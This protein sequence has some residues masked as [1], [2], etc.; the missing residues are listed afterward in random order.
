MKSSP[1]DEHIYVNRK[2]Y[3]FMNFQ[4]VCDANLK[5][6]KVGKVAWEY[7][8][9]FDLVQF[10]IETNVCERH[11]F[12]GTV[13]RRQWLTITSMADDTCSQPNLTGEQKI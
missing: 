3:H 7:P 1:T 10:G 5:F 13:V 12:R 9:F 8:W 11:N 4:G 2:N 6:H